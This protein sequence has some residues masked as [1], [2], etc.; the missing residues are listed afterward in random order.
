[1]YD[2]TY[3]W[4]L[5]KQVNKCNKPETEKK[6]VFPMRRGVRDGQDR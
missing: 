1:M 6:L 3:M 4:N 5:K 2:F